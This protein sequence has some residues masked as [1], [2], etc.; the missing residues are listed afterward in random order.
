[1]RIVVPLLAGRGS[2]AR[3]AGLAELFFSFPGSRPGRH[4]SGLGS[5]S[6]IRPRA[7]TKA[8]AG[9]DMAP[10]GVTRALGNRPQPRQIT[11]LRT[12]TNPRLTRNHA[13]SSSMWQLIKI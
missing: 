9:V 1:M 13:S 3:V 10:A 11:R 2:V 6:L 8:V 7:E 12:D 4:T 5:G